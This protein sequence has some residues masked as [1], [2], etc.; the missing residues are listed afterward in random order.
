MLTLTVDENGR[1]IDVKPRGGKIP[2][3]LESALK[4]SAQPWKTN[5]PTYKGKRV[6]SSFALNIDFGQ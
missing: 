1:V 4:A 5:R 3:G 2:Q 6:K